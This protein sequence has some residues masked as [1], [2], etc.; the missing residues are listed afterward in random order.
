M[1]VKDKGAA[2][3]HGHIFEYKFCALVFLR[4]T[5]QGQKFKLASN[6]GGFRPFDDVFVEYLDDNFIKKHIFVQLKSKTTKLLTMQQ[7]LAETGD[8]SLRE[9]YKSYIQIEEKFNCSEEG[10][11]LE[12]RI[13]E[14]LFIIYTNADVE[15]KLKSNKATNIGEAEFLMTGSSV[16]QFNEEEH[17]AI[18]QHLQDLSKHR[19]FLRRFRIFYRQAN[20]KEMD[21]PIK[22]ELKQ[23]R[24]LPESELDIAYMFFIDIIK[25]WW[26]HKNFFLKDTNSRENDPV[27]KTLEKLRNI[28]NSIRGNLNLNSVLN[29]KIPQ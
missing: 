27:R 20:E 18:Y 9:Y 14:S 11:K 7:L 2:G 4:A 26:Q 8:F 22:H 25:D 24:R 13:D 10:V 3:I 21:R 5:N 29:T 19:E 12:G 28:I 6:V 23:I 17:K 15:G 16:L 1:Y